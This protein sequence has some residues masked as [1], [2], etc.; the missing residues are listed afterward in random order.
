MCM[1]CALCALGHIIFIALSHTSH[2]R[3][4]RG[5]GGAPGLAFARPSGPDKPCIR[6]GHG[7]QRPREF[8]SDMNFCHFSV[9]FNLSGFQH[10]GTCSA[11]QTDSAHGDARPHAVHA[12]THT[13]THTLTHARARACTHH[14]TTSA[15]H[16][17]HKRL[18]HRSSAIPRRRP[19]FDDRQHQ[20]STSPTC[21]LTG[22]AA[23]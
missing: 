10:S 11:I 9:R 21:T 15:P 16:K 23:A 3:V 22:H 6:K 4:L 8:V 13:H 17:I 5:N 14:Q 19:F 1:V 2:L 12:D 18:T 20:T 7:W